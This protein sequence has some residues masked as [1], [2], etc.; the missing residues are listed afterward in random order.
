MI[1][2]FGLVLI[3]LPR[4]LMGL[5]ADEFGTITRVDGDVF[6][7]Y[8]PG[9]KPLG[10]G[11]YFRYDGLNY[12][13][14]RVK[15]GDHFSPGNI[16]RT[17]RNSGA[18]VVF[19]YGDLVNIGSESFLK[20]EEYKRA[21]TGKTVFSMKL[22]KIRTLIKSGG[23]LSGLVIKTPHFK[24]QVQGTEFYLRV[25]PN[26]SFIGLLIEK[27]GKFRPYIRKTGN[28]FQDQ[29]FWYLPVINR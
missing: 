10:P 14:S 29:S 6:R 3:I 11:P 21:E 26:E 28:F 16:I 15:V 9:K 2:L 18:R 19:N 7:L 13:I 25:F 5:S 24:S 27:V 23:K 17:G 4:M 8:Y 1:R 12:S 20:Y 22:G